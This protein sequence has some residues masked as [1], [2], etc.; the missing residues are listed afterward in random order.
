MVRL[1]KKTLNW[2]TKMNRKAKFNDSEF[3]I[4]THHK[5]IRFTISTEPGIKPII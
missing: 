5:A 1:T 3:E 4:I 2:K